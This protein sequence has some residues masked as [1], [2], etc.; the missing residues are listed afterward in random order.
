[1]ISKLTC[2]YSPCLCDKVH[3][4]SSYLEICLEQIICF[5]KGLNAI[6]NEQ[7]SA[8]SFGKAAIGLHNLLN[9][10]NIFDHISLKVS[11]VLIP[12]TQPKF[13]GFRTSVFQNW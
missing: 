3:Y 13:T 1:M 2:T 6:E 8:S 9:T 11:A 12:D 4:L 10:V 7:N 5:L